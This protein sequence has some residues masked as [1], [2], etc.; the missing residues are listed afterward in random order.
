MGLPHILAIFTLKKLDVVVILNNKM[1][2]TEIN[3]VSTTQN[4]HKVT[5]KN[6]KSAKNESN[7]HRKYPKITIRCEND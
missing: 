1:Y 3:G 5:I 6:R 7:L 2:K 4:G